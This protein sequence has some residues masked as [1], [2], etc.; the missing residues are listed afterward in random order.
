MNDGIC[1]M[2]PTKYETMIRVPQEH[3]NP[4]SFKKKENEVMLNY[5]DVVIGNYSILSIEQI[6]LL[7]HDEENHFQVS[8]WSWN[9]FQ[10]PL[11]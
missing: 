6:C 9:Y 11:I 10:N 2:P 1:M 7:W 5:V 8:K 4:L 3:R